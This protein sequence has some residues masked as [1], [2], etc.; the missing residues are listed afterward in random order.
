MEKLKK[1][2]EC[3]KK[4]KLGENYIISLD[5]KDTYCIPCSEELTNKV[6][7]IKH[8]FRY[9]NKKWQNKKII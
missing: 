6:R 1:C 5:E 2:S 3:G 8:G 9:G 4:L 7:K